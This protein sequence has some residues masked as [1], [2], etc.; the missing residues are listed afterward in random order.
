M[1]SAQN[2]QAGWSVVGSGLVLPDWLNLQDTDKTF[3][4][5]QGQ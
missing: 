5:S 3:L 1:V 4:T 2:T